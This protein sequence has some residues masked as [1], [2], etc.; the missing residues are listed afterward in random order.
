MLQFVLYNVQLKLTL[1]T[2]LFRSNAQQI[3][4]RSPPA[5]AS[6]HNYTR[7]KLTATINASIVKQFQI[8]VYTVTKC[9]VLLSTAGIIEI[10]IRSNINHKKITY[11]F[12]Q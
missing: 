6:F 9:L 11:L 8:I 5:A 2:Q 1:Q 12:N 3:A 4:R 10:T 7:L